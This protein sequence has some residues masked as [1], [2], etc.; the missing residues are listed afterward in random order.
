MR[1]RRLL[2]RAGSKK[3]S[4]IQIS[5]MTDTML[6]SDMDA[7]GICDGS[8]VQIGQQVASAAPLM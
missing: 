7:D 6:K 1:N 5:P 8:R 4:Y 3:T 2:F